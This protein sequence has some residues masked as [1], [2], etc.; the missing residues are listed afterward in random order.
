M[1]RFAM[2]VLLLTMVCCGGKVNLTRPGTTQE[3]FYRDL[4]ECKKYANQM[5]AMMS[6]PVG[7]VSNMGIGSV[8]GSGI[9]SGIIYGA[10]YNMRLMEC[11]KAK[12]YTEVK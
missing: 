9:G 2:I 3:E 12:G 6:G 1:K 7:N 10:E 8:I 4:W 5:A 11:M